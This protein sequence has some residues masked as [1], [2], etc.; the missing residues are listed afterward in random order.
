MNKIMNW[1]KRHMNVPTA[2]LVFFSLGFFAYLI[3]FFGPQELASSLL[4]NEQQASTTIGASLGT[5]STTTV[6]TSTSTETIAADETT[7]VGAGI[8][9]SLAATNEEIASDGTAISASLVSTLDEVSDDSLKSASA[10]NT[11]ESTNAATTSVLDTSGATGISSTYSREVAT[12]ETAR[13]VTTS[14]AVAT[15]RTTTTAERA[16]QTPRTGDEIFLLLGM[17][18]F[19]GLGVEAARRRRNKIL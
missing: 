12:F 1:F 11:A 8:A 18:G 6:V 15:A 13:S 17:S 4:G 5:E 7:S 9:G 3:N 14:S 16:P 2:L 19:V 10:E